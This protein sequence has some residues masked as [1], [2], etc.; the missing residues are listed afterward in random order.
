MNTQE[1]MVITAIAENYY[2]GSQNGL[3]FQFPTDDAAGDTDVLHI[4]LAPT[5]QVEM[6]Y[7]SE[8]EYARN[9]VPFPHYVNAL[10]EIH[11]GFSEEFFRELSQTLHRIDAKLPYGTCF[12]KVTAIT[13]GQT[14]VVFSYESG[15]PV[16]SVAGKFVDLPQYNVN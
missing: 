16:M 11:P 8:R 1:E 10:A 12:S 14:T 5:A 4:H 3:A 6:D 7:T 13:T 15:K 9:M 2:N